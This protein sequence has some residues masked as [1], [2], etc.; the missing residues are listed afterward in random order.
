MASHA[1]IV[2]SGGTPSWPIFCALASSTVGNHGPGPRGILFLKALAPRNRASPK[3]AKS[4]FKIQFSTMIHP[5][6]G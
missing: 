6:Y 4:W 2:R 3:L 1:S 5:N